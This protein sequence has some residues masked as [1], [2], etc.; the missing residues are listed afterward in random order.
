MEDEYLIGICGNCG[1]DII[2]H[3]K[4]KLEEG[5]P[6]HIKCGREIEF[7]QIIEE[8]GVVEK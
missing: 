1:L 8:I 5:K 6:K 3:E 7:E 4:W 2:S